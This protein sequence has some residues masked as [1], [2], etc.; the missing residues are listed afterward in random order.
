M[1]KILELLLLI[2]A[3][4]APQQ[5]FGFLPAPSSIGAPT[6]GGRGLEI[7]R[8]RAAVGDT[9]SSDE[10]S[11]T[12]RREL[13]RTA[14]GFSLSALLTAGSFAPAPVLAAERQPLDA[15]LYRILRVKEAV[16]QE[17]RLIKSGK[18]KDVQRA[19]VKLAVKFMINNYRLNDAF[20]T[21]SAYLDSNDRRV[22]AGQVGQSAVQ[23]LYTIL[24]Y[25]DSSD[26]QNIKVNRNR[27]TNMMYMES[28]PI[29]PRSD[30]VTTFCHLIIN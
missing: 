29:R 11:S 24:E 21:A 27:S 16:Q 12:S 9:D 13:F 14:F 7:L 18:F 19:N 6:T 25:F 20:V 28:I 15:V 22:E 10:E 2:G 23:N 30:I 8:R 5:A 17:T 3:F 26:I 1:A 4:S